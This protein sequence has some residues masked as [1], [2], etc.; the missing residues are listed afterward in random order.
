VITFKRPVL[1][2]EMS[3]PNLTPVM[4]WVT[5]PAS[6]FT[7]SVSI[8]FGNQEIRSRQCSKCRQLFTYSDKTA[9]IFDP[10]RAVCIQCERV[11]IFKETDLLN[12]ADYSESVSYSEL[13]ETS[14][15]SEELV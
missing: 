14:S 3:K 4:R 5:D 12:G 8:T 9:G 11:D 6:V 2:S 7:E 1:L 10:Y 13:L 15:V